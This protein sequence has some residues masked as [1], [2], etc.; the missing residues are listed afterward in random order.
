[1]QSYGR[2]GSTDL[3]E[4][5]IRRGMEWHRDVIQPIRSLRRQLRQQPPVGVEAET[6]ELRH[7]L[8]QAELAA[9]RIEQRLY[10]QDLPDNLPV[11]AEPWRDAA[12]NAALMMRKNCPQPEP[13]AL[14][15]LVE[16]LQA[17]SPETPTA[18]L[19]QEVASVWIVR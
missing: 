7:Q 5:A 15:A 14:G 6:H 3:V 9:E 12:I 13:E 10:L 4:I 8:V 1:M 16:I 19:H 11:S 18:E 2:L 17:A